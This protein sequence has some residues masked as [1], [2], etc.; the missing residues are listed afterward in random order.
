MKLFNSAM[1]MNILAIVALATTIV[2]LPVGTNSK[3]LDKRYT[4]YGDAPFG[5]KRDDGRVWV[6]GSWPPFGPGDEVEDKKRFVQLDSRLL[7]TANSEN[8]LPFHPYSDIQ[9]ARRD[10]D[11][12]L[13]P[14]PDDP[15]SP[16]PSPRSLAKRTGLLQG[17]EFESLEPLDG[18]SDI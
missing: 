6:Y 16:P 14:V 18:F 8:T 2:A 9:L 11:A 4:I 12:L 10:V 15:P 3:A 7:H 17:E 5:V 13:L 1:V